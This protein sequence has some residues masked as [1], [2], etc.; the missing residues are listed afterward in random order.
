[1]MFNPLYMVKDFGEEK[2]FAF[3]DEFMTHADTPTL[4]FSGFI[5]NPVNPATGNPVTDAD[6]QNDVQIVGASDWNVEE[7]NGTT[8]KDTSYCVLRNHDL[9]VPENWSA[10]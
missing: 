10:E 2:P 8:F 4:A 6:K 3:S 7:N 1:M 9:R 5:E